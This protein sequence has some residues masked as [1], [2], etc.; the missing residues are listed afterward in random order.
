M[1]RLAFT[2]YYDGLEKELAYLIQTQGGNGCG[3]AFKNK[4][5]NLEIKK[6]INYNAEICTTIIKS[7]PE[8]DSYA[9][10]HTRLSTVGYK[11]D[12]LCHPFQVNTTKAVAHNG[13]W[14]GY[15][16]ALWSI[17]DKINPKTF[18]LGISDTLVASKLIENY[19]EHILDIIDSGV[20]IVFNAIDATA[21]LYYYS[22]SFLLMELNDNKWIYASDFSTVKGT[23]YSP[24]QG[25]IISL[26][27][28]GPKI[29]RGDIQ[30]TNIV[31]HILPITNRR[32]LSLNGIYDTYDY[33]DEND[34]KPN[35]KYKHHV[36]VNNE[37]AAKQC[38]FC[39]EHN[40]FIVHSA[41]KTDGE[42]I[43]LNLCYDCYDQILVE[44]QKDNI[45]IKTLYD[46]IVEEKSNINQAI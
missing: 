14:D 16:Y 43:Q 46:Y 40:A 34:I 24:Q 25:S 29:E 19:G 39:D 31:R 20:W 3:V 4:A 45:G 21:K 17:I 30:K 6:G 41:Q 8:Q 1:C 22:G 28:D 32:I 35:V 12:F 11:N 42:R 44:I 13:H 9:L 27:K 33:F 26:T 15:K 37:T 10:F 23:C 7:E 5:G 2:Y 38:M 36:H 18:E